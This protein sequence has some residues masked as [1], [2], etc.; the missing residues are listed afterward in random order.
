MTVCRL[1]SPYPNKIVRISPEMRTP[2]YSGTPLF[3]PPEIKTPLYTVEPLYYNYL[4][5]GH[6]YM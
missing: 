4:K 6:L 1:V 3:P 5:R 2:I